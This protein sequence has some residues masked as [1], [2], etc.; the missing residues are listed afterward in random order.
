MYTVLTTPGMI[1][2]RIESK[3]IVVV[4]LYTGDETG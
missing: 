2:Y 4:A 1:Y 3:N